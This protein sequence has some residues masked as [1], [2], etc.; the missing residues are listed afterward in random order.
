MDDSPKPLPNKAS[1]SP[2]ISPSASSGKEETDDST[3][4]KDKGWWNKIDQTLL[5]TIALTF[6]SFCALFVSIYQTQVL[7]LQQEVMAEQQRIM[8]ENAKAQAWPNIEVSYMKST[9]G[10]TT[11]IALRAMEFSIANTGTGPAI[12]EGVTVQF[13][14]MYLKGW[15]ELFNAGN[16]PD[17]IPNA[18]DT[19]DEIAGQVIQAGEQYTFLSF[20]NNE[21]MMNYLFDEIQE[22]NGFTIT[23]CYKSVFDDHWQLKEKIGSLNLRAVPVDSC[24]IAD[25]IAFFN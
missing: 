10:D 24:T 3:Q 5:S 4:E 2:D 14:E 17:T 11:G 6:I 18:F 13:K 16:L 23:I 22:G 8:T 15:W 7:S 9:V 1:T 12:V 21:P 19:V 25:S 20:N